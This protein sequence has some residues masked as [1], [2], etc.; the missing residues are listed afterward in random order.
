MPTVG[1]RDQ[2]VERLTGLGATM[3]VDERKPDG[4]G[5]VTMADPEGNQ[6]RV[7]RGAAERV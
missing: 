4:T 7:K 6:F 5:L 2:E 1:T 3:V